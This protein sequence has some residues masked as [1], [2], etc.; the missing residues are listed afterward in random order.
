M[1]FNL[2]RSWMLLLQRGGLAILFGVLA[3]L[4]PALTLDVLVLLFGGYALIDG[5]L[6][7]AV[8]IPN[9]DEDRPLWPL[10]LQGATGIAAGLVTFYWPRITALVLLY[11]IGIWA[12]VTGIFELV[13]ASRLR[14]QVAGSEGLA[15][16]GVLSILF[17]LFVIL[18]PG[19]GALAVVWLIAAYAIAF[20]LLL[21]ALG[22][23]LR[24]GTWDWRN[25]RPPP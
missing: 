4:W 15:L 23:R 19:A 17:G 18:F 2:A 9:S 12:V 6:A 21:L 20:G 22:F 13:A 1:E 10:I 7:L 3:L 11:L 8:A 14:Q 5:V 16:A 25:S 24:Q